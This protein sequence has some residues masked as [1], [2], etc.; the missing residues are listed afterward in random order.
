MSIQHG[1]SPSPGLGAGGDLLPTACQGPRP[2]PRLQETSG[3]GG[4]LGTQPLTPQ[5]ALGPCSLGPQT[6]VFCGSEHTHTFWASP[7]EVH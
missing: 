3:G 5:P 2:L 7:Q 4:M 6:G 1:R